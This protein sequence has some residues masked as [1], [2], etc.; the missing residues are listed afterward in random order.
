MSKKI[1]ITGG[2]GYLGIML[3]N[4]LSINPDLL[5]WNGKKDTIKK[6][7]L[8]D[9]FA[10]T[11]NKP[12]LLNNH[13][14][15]ISDLSNPKSVQSIAERDYDTIFHF[16]SAVSAACHQN[17]ELGEKN[18][19]AT[20]T[21]LEA[22]SKIYEESNGKR[23]TVVFPSSYLAFEN[24][25]GINDKTKPNAE[26]PY[27]KSKILSEKLGLKYLDKVNFRGLR[28]PTVIAFRKPTTAA[29]AYAYNLPNKVLRGDDCTIPV[30]PEYKMPF[31]W[32]SEVIEAFVRIHNVDESLLVNEN[33]E[34]YRMLNLSGQSPSTEEWVKEIESYQD[35]CPWGFGKIIWEIDS[36]TMEVIGSA[37]SYITGELSKKLGIFS[38]INFKDMIKNI[39][40]EV[41]KEN[42]IKK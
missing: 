23:T 11:L 14:I 39:Y 31:I 6:I 22:A 27:G 16:G 5:R 3:A 8:L 20:K 1:L 4:K 37:A 32:I 13:E 9:I 25:V 26:S 12:L 40:E 10:E 19:K 42:L 38:H 17:P 35:M 7:V 15:Q 21:V 33:G 2:L 28:L 36:T 41:K 18:I 34:P 29:T 30:P 24:V